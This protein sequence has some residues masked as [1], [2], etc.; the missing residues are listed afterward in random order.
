MSEFPE[1]FFEELKDAIES[2]VPSNYVQTMFRDRPYNGQPHTADGT[3][4][5]TEV[6]GLTMRDVRDCFIRG[7]FEA[8]VLP[9][10]KWPKTIYDLP[11]D[12]MD[13]MAVSQNMLCEMEKMMGIYPN[14]PPLVEREDA[15]HE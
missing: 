7:C 10:E 14:V 4:G 1:E 2:L 12:E 11:W 8:S 13:P 9:R 6:K 15:E 3:R 5:S